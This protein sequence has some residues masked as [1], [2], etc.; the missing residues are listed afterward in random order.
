MFDQ[1]VNRFYKAFCHPPVGR[2]T[3]DYLMCL[4][5]SSQ[6]AAEYTREFCML[7]AGNK[8]NE[9]SVISEFC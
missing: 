6:S 5:Q 3:S 8:L 4:K 2:E 7:A 9:P 1:C